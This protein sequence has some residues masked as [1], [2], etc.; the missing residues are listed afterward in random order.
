MH[1]ICPKTWR[2]TA[3]RFL[4]NQ[5]LPGARLWAFALARQAQR[6]TAEAPMQG[7]MAQAVLPASRI[8]EPLCGCIL[9]DLSTEACRILAGSDVLTELVSENDPFRACSNGP[10][11]LC[12]VCIWFFFDSDIPFRMGPSI[13]LNS[14]LEVS[15]RNPFQRV[16]SMVSARTD[17]GSGPG[18]PV[19]CESPSH[20]SPS[21]WLSDEGCIPCRPQRLP[22]A[23]PTPGNGSSTTTAR[24]SSMMC[25]KGLGG[26]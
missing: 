23:P 7:S 21:P 2:G 8:A 26:T 11:L 10:P 17:F 3:S 4:H 24:T 18:C 5:T 25:H 1:G 16:P 9:D 15:L 19:S 20:L 13:F 22:P 14:A 12:M 6:S